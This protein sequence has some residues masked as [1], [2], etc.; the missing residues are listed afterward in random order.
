MGGWEASP[1]YGRKPRSLLGCFVL[2]P[3]SVS[4]RGRR[5]AASPKTHHLYP[6][7]LNIPSTTTTNSRV[8]AE[9]EEEDVCPIYELLML[10]DGGRISYLALIV[11]AAVVRGES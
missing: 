1:W 3:P 7:I 11:L 10:S 8:V 2:A 6:F 5:G 9:E 4:G